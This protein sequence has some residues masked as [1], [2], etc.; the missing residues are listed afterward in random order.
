VQ[1][2]EAS[3]ISDERAYR[4]GWVYLTYTY[5][6]VTALDHTVRT[7][8]TLEVNREEVLLAT[9]D[10][11][12]QPH[13]NPSFHLGSHRGVIYNL[14]G[15]LHEFLYRLDLTADDPNVTDCPVLA[16]CDACL[17][18]GSCLSTCAQN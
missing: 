17:G 3:A 1:F 10:Y 8:V 13:W 18:D 5:E 11:I 6:A 16:T 14:R 9:S 4:G 7:D 12:L 15:I 2:G